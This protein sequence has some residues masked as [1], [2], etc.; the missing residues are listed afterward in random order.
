M[1]L[2]VNYI[3]YPWGAI[4]SGIAF[5]VLGI[6]ITERKLLWRWIMNLFRATRLLLQQEENLKD[7]VKPFITGVG[8]YPEPTK[9][10]ADVPYITINLGWDNRS[11]RAVKLEDIRGA[12]S[13][14]RHSPL[15]DLPSIVNDVNLRAWQRQDNSLIIAVNLTG[16]GLNFI[17]SI[18]D[19]GS[20]KAH[21]KLDLKAQLNGERVTFESILYKALYVG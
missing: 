2:L 20:G 4:L 15:N 3:A 12:V 10:L 9:K 7:F 1:A 17:Q 11:F 14:E 19:K 13:V 21:I 16:D 5:L 6:I 18:R 8:I